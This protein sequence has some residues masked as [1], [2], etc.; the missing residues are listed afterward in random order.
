MFN[1]QGFKIKS[2]T[3]NLVMKMWNI[4]YPID[5]AD[6]KRRRLSKTIKTWW[7]HNLQGA[8]LKFTKCL[9]IIILSC[10]N[11]KNMCDTPMNGEFC[12]L[13][14]SVRVLMLKQPQKSTKLLFWDVTDFVQAH[15]KSNFIFWCF[16]EAIWPQDYH[17]WTFSFKY[18]NKDAFL[19]LKLF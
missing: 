11:S 1:E 8:P 5:P 17:I 3:W 2:T 15:L 12:Q 19:H 6:I 4:C 13:S 9:K 16:F 10:I 14:E 18:H 7:H